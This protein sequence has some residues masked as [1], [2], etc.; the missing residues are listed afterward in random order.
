MAIRSPVA[1]T[2]QRYI[3]RDEQESEGASWS[4][5][6][7]AVLYPTDSK[8]CRFF[9][10]AQHM[11]LD[12]LNVAHPEGLRMFYVSDPHG[13]VIKDLQNLNERP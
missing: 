8:R 13:A 12:R 2:L 7:K 11:L 6:R 10:V 3:Q 9:A 5:I 4:A 1:G